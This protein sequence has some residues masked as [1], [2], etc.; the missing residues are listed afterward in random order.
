MWHYLGVPV[1]QAAAAERPEVTQGIA[2]YVR[3]P[4]PLQRCLGNTACPH[5][6]IWYGQVDPAHRHA[7]T[8]N[9]WSQQ[10]Y[11]EQGAA[12]PKPQDRHLDIKPAE[13][14]WLWLGQANEATSPHYDTISLDVA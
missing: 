9:R 2:R 11:V 4:E 1:K 10:A 13:V 5:T 12:F 3:I 8:Y 7:K 6:G 14:R